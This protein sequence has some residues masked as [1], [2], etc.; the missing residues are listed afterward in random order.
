M[1]PHALLRRLARAER[2]FTEHRRAAAGRWFDLR[3]GVRTETGL[4]H[5]TRVDGG[6]PYQPSWPG[7]V[8]RTARLLRLG[9]GDV[10]LDAGS[11]LGRVPFALAACSPVRTAIGV[12]ADREL[13]EAALRNLGAVRTRLPGRDIRL[14]H[15]DV[16]AQA[17]P[18]E[19]T[20]VY[21]FN[22]FD[23]AGTA[24]LLERIEESLARRPRTLTV[25]YL[26]PAHGEVFTGAGFRLATPTPYLHLYRR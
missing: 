22:P 13:H 5:Q 26:C 24:R 2:R 25:A 20:V 23:R 6:T 3:L 10:V 8:R 7:L 19:V 17:L 11:G 14:R 15:G 21:L 9:P 16:T 12:E 1:P 4:V 18:D